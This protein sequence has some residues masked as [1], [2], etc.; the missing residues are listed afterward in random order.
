MKKKL[1]LM[2]LVLGCFLLL[3]ARAEA[4]TIPLSNQ[5]ITGGEFVANFNN[6]FNAGPLLTLPFSISGD[7]S[8]NV[9]SGVAASL[10]GNLYIYQYAIEVNSSTKHSL[11]GFS[12]VWGPAAPL[13]FDFGGGPA[14]SFTLDASDGGNS[15]L[16]GNYL[17]DSGSYATGDGAANWGFS[18]LLSANDSSSWLFLISDEPPGLI[19]ASILD[20]SNNVVSGDVYAPVPEPATLLFL[21]SGLLG[22]GV[23]ARR[24]FIKK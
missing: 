19:P 7:A 20:G 10:T 13:S 23:Y 12:F 4:V 22:I 24:R 14:N 3:T 9:L 16:V 2:V 8:G 17:P 15:S 6:V 11:E 1:L 5:E 18:Y 21:G